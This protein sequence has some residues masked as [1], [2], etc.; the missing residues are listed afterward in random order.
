MCAALWGG[1]SNAW[2]GVA[3]SVPPDIPLNITVG[4]TIASTLRITHQNDGTEAGQNDVIDPGTITLVPSCG[5]NPVGPNCPA[6]SEDPG[7]LVPSATGTGV[8]GT[9]CDGITFTFT[10][11]NAAMGKYTLTWPGT[12]T[13]TPT[14][15]TQSC[16]ISFTTDVKKMPTKDANAVTAGLQTSQASGAN[17]TAQGPGNLPGSGTGSD[18]ATVLQGAIAIQTQVSPTPIVLGAAFH[19]TA[20]ITK[21]AVGPTPTG[22]VKFD[23]YG[24]GDASCAG[25]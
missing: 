1:A 15:A 11:T 22:T 23:V 13:L 24:P 19:D 5:A 12:I 25:T 2:A 21:P 4:T 8:S 20:T 17:A 18:Q 10:L 16:I 7:V 9:A 14:G 6:G 3:L